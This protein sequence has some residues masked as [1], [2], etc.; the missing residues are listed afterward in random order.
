MLGHP[1]NTNDEEMAI[2]NGRYAKEMCG[3]GRNYYSGRLG[4]VTVPGGTLLDVGCGHCQWSEAA[5]SHGM[6][7]TGC[8]VL[9]TP[10]AAEVAKA[11]ATFRLVKANSEHL[12]FMANSFDVVLCE[13]VLPYVNVE[14]SLGEIARVLRP[15]G[16]AHAICH[17]AGY[18]LLQLVKELQHSNKRARRRALVLLYTTI[19][20]V[21]RFKEYRYESFQ[22]ISQI[23]RLLSSLAFSNISFR[24][25]GHPIISRS[26]FAGLPCFFEFTARREPT[27]MVKDTA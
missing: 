17:G 26:R 16:V 5:I 3:K 18:Y 15:G 23:E 1:S 25:G 27:M 8:D 10:T 20:R 13:L 2:F 12:P 19:H 24:V 9:I 21:C 11:N 7:V 22:T 14:R 4:V 6:K